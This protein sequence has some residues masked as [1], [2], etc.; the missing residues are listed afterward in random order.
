[1]HLLFDIG[2][3]RIRV[4]V[5]ADG[6]T[7]DNYKI[8]N[9]PQSYAE[10]VQMIKNLAL[11]LNPAGNFTAIVGGLPGPM[12]TNRDM[13]AAA[14]HLADWVNK[15]IKQ[16]L[17]EL[18]TGPIFIENDT[19]IVGLGEAAYGAAR[20]QSIV[21][22]VTV[23]TG[24]GGVRVI[25]KQ[26]DESLYGFEPGH[27]IL[28]FSADQGLSQLKHF[29]ELVSGSGLAKQYGTDVNQITDPAVWDQVHKYL[30]VGLYN[31]IQFWSPQVIVVGGGLINAELINLD[32]L[33]QY[34]HSIPSVFPDYPL[35]VKAELK[36][37]GGLYG[38][39][40][41]LKYKLP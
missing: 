37:V 6:Q 22:Y 3:T 21:A 26:L 24:F 25:N 1:M 28:N 40:A 15:P 7:V 14:P 12:D 2:G 41:L 31:L 32:K 18:T 20:E 36:D 30:A 13:L 39:L 19:A 16:D 9:T 5:S 35:L 4:G 17:Q 33:N 34:L 27:H 8:V 11:E 10:G 29:E 23:S 38:A